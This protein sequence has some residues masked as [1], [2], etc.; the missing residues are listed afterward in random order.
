MAVSK[1]A[2]PPRLNWTGGQEAYLR[3]SY[4]DVPM[5]KL[6]AVLRR[7]ATAIQARAKV[8]GLKRSAAFLAGDHGGRMRPGD[9]RGLSTRFGARDVRPGDRQIEC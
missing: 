5:V 7:S 1:R 4:P 2:Q 6:M 9:A 8:L 3:A